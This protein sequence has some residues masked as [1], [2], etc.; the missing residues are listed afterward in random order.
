LGGGLF[1]A[2][3]RVRAAPPGGERFSATATYGANLHFGRYLYGPLYLLLRAEAARS[4]Y[5]NPGEVRLL[6]PDFELRAS[7]SVAA[8]WSSEQ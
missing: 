3:T 1:A 2:V 8:T 6:D 4:F 5:A 7:A